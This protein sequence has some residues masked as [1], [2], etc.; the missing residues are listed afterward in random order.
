MILRTVPAIHRVQSTTNV[1][2]R[3]LNSA[4]YL[5]RNR[6]YNDQSTDC[7]SN[8]LPLGGYE[9]KASLRNCF[10]S[11]LGGRPRQQRKASAT[12][13][14]F[15]APPTAKS[16]IPL[17]SPDFRSKYSTKKS[18]ASTPD[19]K[20]SIN[21][22]CCGRS[23]RSSNSKAWT[24]PSIR[25]PARAAASVP[26]LGI[27]PPR[28]YK[29]ED[30]KLDFQ[31]TRHVYIDAPTCSFSSLARIDPQHRAHNFHLSTC[32]SISHTPQVSRPS[33]SHRARVKIKSSRIAS[34]S[35]IA[36]PLSNLLSA[37]AR[38]QSPS[39]SP[40]VPC[41]YHPPTCSI[42]AI[43]S[44]NLTHSWNR[45]FWPRYNHH[46][47]RVM[48]FRRPQ[49]RESSSDTHGSRG[50]SSGSEGSHDEYT[51]TRNGRL[52]HHM[53][54]DATT[55]ATSAASNGH[56]NHLQDHHNHHEHDHDHDHG[57][58]HSHSIFGG[59]SH[60]GD[61][62]AQDM[63]RVMAALKGSRECHFSLGLLSAFL[64]FPLRTCPCMLRCFIVLCVSVDMRLWR[65]RTPE[66]CISLGISTHETNG[67]Q[68]EE[69][70]LKRT[71]GRYT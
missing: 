21:K 67:I 20:T 62:R 32:S 4:I 70:G 66:S 43:S 22:S 23:I 28:E 40:P 54:V 8:T 17:R 18:L 12:S 3:R 41:H 30:Q 42:F 10:E 49:R 25:D 26:V 52:N 68:Q 31:P 48:S 16:F 50:R 47:F 9:I 56:E 1:W 35:E 59:H 58:G 5:R 2:T 64:A 46:Y 60:G 37:S 13:P 71:H 36:T 51:H 38:A 69:L 45:S 19:S 14:P 24:K 55:T 15:S 61:E 53:T 34:P 65:R 39:G 7:A 44:C 27:K 6:R 29:P 57:H 63:Q 33:Q 11:D